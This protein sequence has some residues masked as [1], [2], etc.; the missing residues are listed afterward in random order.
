MKVLITGICGFVG[1]VLARGLIQ[2]WDVAGDHLEIIGLDNF[3]RPGSETNKTELKKL[4]VRLFHGDIRL[5]EDVENLPVVDWVI[6]AAANASVLAGVDGSVSSRQIMNY[7]LSST[8]NLLEYCKKCIA[9]FIL[10]STSRV[11]SISGLASLPIKS[12]TNAFSLNTQKPLA[13]GVSERG[14]CEKFSTQ[15]PISLYGVSKLASESIALEYGDCFNFPVWI[16]RCGVLAGA[17]QFGRPDQGIFSY[18]INSYLRKTPL[19]YIGFDGTGLQVRD[20]FHP[21][22]LIPLIKKQFQQNPSDFPQTINLGGGIK[23]KMS[24]KELSLWCEDRF[25]K[26]DIAIDTNMRLFDIP[27]M[28]MDYGLA[29]KTWGWKPSIDMEEILSEI[30]SHAEKNKNWLELSAGF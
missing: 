26:H 7:N 19:K 11:Y 10:L 22:D 20:C 2:H 25:G 21:L 12:D 15:P 4:G 27:W 28:V 8:L 30:A 23:N 9:G 18:W 6:D 13:E 3:S 17:G 5:R 14:I 29:E 1:S 16:N 24:L